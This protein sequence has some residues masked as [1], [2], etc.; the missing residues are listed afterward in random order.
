MKIASKLHLFYLAVLIVFC[1]TAL[2]L[3][4]DL[5]SVSNGYNAVLN[6]PVRQMEEARIVQLNFKKQVQEWKDI[7]LRGHN[8]DDLAK[9]TRQFHEKEGLV[10]EGAKAL[11]LEVEDP[12][13][14][15]LLEQFLQAH[16]ALSQKYQ[17]AYGAYLA[18]NSDFKAADNLVRGQDR[19]PTDLFDQVAQRLDD[20]AK[21]S[22]AAQTE[23]AVR[24]RNLAFA[25]SGVLLLLLGGMGL[26]L[27]Q[28][29]LGRL[30]RL[31][32]VSDQLARAD[33]SGLTLDVSGHDEIAEFGSSLK[34]VHAAIEELLRLVPAK[35][36]V[37]S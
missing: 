9:Y 7:L 1:L 29:I 8:P 10:R 18:G 12:A 36:P 4:A 37:K 19:A 20:R 27:V 14:K 16:S 24:A 34:G 13:A 32:L 26:W 22:I 17:A 5:Q 2:A 35:T 23:A 25:I 33:L 15:Q 31:K 6:S 28:D 21:Q 30:G 3:A 11:S